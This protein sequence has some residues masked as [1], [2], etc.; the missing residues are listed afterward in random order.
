M[1]EQPAAIVPL[2]RNHAFQWLLGGSS[3]SMLGSRLTT[4]AYPLLILAL[5]GSAA[6]AGLAVFAANA[7]SVLVYIPAGALVDRSADPKR[8]LIIAEAVRGAAIAVIV[9]MLVFH[10]ASIHWIILMAIVEESSEVFANLAERRYVRFLVPPDQVSAAQVSIEARTHIVVLAGRALGGLLFGISQVLPF[11]ADLMSFA[12]S[13]VSLA[14]IRRGK[15][16]PPSRRRE[17]RSSLRGEVRDGLRELF[18]DPS[19]RNA[20]LLSASMTLISQALIIVFLAAAHNRGVS[21]AVIGTVLAFSG[22]GGLLGALISQ[23]VLRPV[24]LSPLKLQPFIWTC[25]LIVL[26]LSGGLQVQ[27]MALVMTALGTAGAVGNVALDTYVLVK[28][29]DKKLARVTSIEMLLDFAACAL[30]PAL[31]G[32]LLEWSG[33]TANAIWWLAGLSA[34]FAAITLLAPYFRVHARPA[35]SAQPPI[36]GEMPPGKLASSVESPVPV[37]AVSG[38]P[39]ADLR[40]GGLTGPERRQ[41]AGHRARLA[42]ASASGGDG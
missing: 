13:V 35:F 3:V 8:M 22:F 12:V 26:A 21:S 30:G 24:N 40:V 1:S 31:G 29:P 19:A 6:V 14:R 38:P 11:C 32:L 2:R 15:E 18:K 7:P 23:R 4:I 42:R 28:V 9:G 17:R 34:A 27:A 39:W 37:S 25:M 16:R 10:R 33:S 20:S 5:H 36:P 41:M